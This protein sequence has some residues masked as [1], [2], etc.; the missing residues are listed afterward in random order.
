MRYLFI[1]ASFCIIDPQI[2]DAATPRYVIC[3]RND[4]GAITLRLR[5][6]KRTETKIS[7]ISMLTGA[8]GTDGTDGSDG[9]DGSIRVYGDGSAG[10]LLVPNTA[11]FEADNKQFAS[12]TIDSGVTLTVDSGTIL[13]VSGT[14]TNNGTIEV[15]GFASGA[16]FSSGVATSGTAPAF[17][18]ANSGIAPLAGA[19]PAFGTDAATVAGGAYGLGM[20]EGA[21]MNVLNP[22][23]LG[24]SGGGAG[25][26]GNTGGKGG[27]TFTVLAA[28]AIVNNGT[29]T[30]NGA[31]GDPGSGGGGGG[32][33]ILASQTSV[34]NAASATI[35]ANGGAGGAS[36]TESGAGGGGGGGIIHLI[37]ATAPVNSGTITV[38]GGAA[39]NNATAVTSSPRSGGGGG[40]SCGGEGG[41]G[42]SVSALGTSSGN[43]LGADGFSFL[44]TADPTSL[45]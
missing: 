1:L 5:R 38:G 44:T 22:G 37:S 9:A 41:P 45:F 19:Q 35:S 39:G 20:F 24:G 28:G 23:M 27:G 3:E 13:R 32:V 15:R 16:E 4:S 36:N 30:A 31:A 42:S 10:D 26:Y 34:T 2:A 40:G 8:P 18:P 14:F 6:C 7:N 21:A 17:S 25:A 29:I 12:V 11:L 43:S 33:I